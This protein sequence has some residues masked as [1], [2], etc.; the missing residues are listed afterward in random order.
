MS[1]NVAKKG[2]N[3]VGGIDSEQLESIV[4]RVEALNEEKANITAAIRDIY[5]E[6][7]GNGFEVKAIRECVKQRAMDAA[8]REEREA[9]L[10]TY[11]MALGLITM[12]DVV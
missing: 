3:R 11:R 5:S 1:K 12:D 9:V 6:A 2:H 8:E 10:D 7:K 4:K